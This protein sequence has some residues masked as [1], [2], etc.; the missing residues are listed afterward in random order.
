MEKESKK[1]KKSKS[2]STE[3]AEN[4]SDDPKPIASLDDGTKGKSRRRL[5]SSIAAFLE[6]NGFH[7]TLP[8]FRSEAELESGGTEVPSINLEDLFGKFLESSGGLEKAAI[9]CQDEKDMQ[10]TDASSK[11]EVEHTDDVSEHGHRKKKKHRKETDVGTN[12]GDDEHGLDKGIN[13]PKSL[14][15]TNEI[16]KLK[17]A[18]DLHVEIK[19]KRK[20]KKSLPLSSEED[21]D[22]KHLENSC[23]I[24]ENG[25]IN[26]KAKKKKKDK[27]HK[28]SL[29]VHDGN[30]ES[31]DH[32]KKV[33]ETVEEK[34]AELKSLT[35]MSDVP[36][37]SNAKH[38]GEK[39]K[40]KKGDATSDSLVIDGNKQTGEALKESESVKENTAKSENDDN[41]EHKPHKKRK[42]VASEDRALE[43][44]TEDKTSKHDKLGSAENNMEHGTPQGADKSLPDSELTTISK[45]R[46]IQKVS[47][48][49]DEAAK[50]SHQ[51]ENPSGQDVPKESGA[52]QLVNGELEKNKKD[53]GTASKST[54]KEKRSAEPK[55][56]N[57]FQRVKIDDVK[58]ADE[59]LQD[60]SYW[61]LDGAGSG[62]GAKAQEV[63]GQ[64]RGRDFRHE[65]TKKKRGTYRGGQIDLQAHSIKF[66]YSDEE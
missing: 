17:S 49:S 61:A 42:R 27:S 57:A 53:A 10:K 26:D 5:L 55:T 38:K 29:D 36:A 56:V 18:E 21:A 32:K 41:V 37:E 9:E 25:N 33:K 6:S 65:K 24:S 62:Y 16:E 54:K 66:N 11:D 46:K 59:R 48:S 3:T 52:D 8:V 30:T 15:D 64:V 50:A 12:T 7:K 39:K 14:G 2:K 23:G 40:K 13:G 31:E 47:Q 35:S 1:K 22:K 58:F 20:K 63:L 28:T 43:D 51:E 45:K 34:I 60:N 19:D 44:G 4:G